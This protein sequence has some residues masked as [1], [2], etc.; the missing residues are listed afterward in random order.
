MQVKIH[1]TSIE[2]KLKLNLLVLWISE[3]DFPLLIFSNWNEK[4]VS[5]D[6]MSI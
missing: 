2:K 3:F 1:Y 4:K 5:I 6:Y